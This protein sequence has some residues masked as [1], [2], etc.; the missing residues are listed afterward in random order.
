[1]WRAKPTRTACLKFSDFAEAFLR[2][3][4][5]RL[6]HAMLLLKRDLHRQ[7]EFMDAAEI[8]DEVSKKVDS[9]ADLFGSP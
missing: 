3:L 8:P 9:L 1:M 6:G 2:R 4:A 7:V 5:E